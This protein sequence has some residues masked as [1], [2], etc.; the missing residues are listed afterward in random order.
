MK[1]LIV[2]KR[3]WLGTILLMLCGFAFAASYNF[4]TIDF[5]DAAQTRA[6]GINDAGNI[7]G[8]YLRDLRQHGF[9]SRDGEFTTIDAPIDPQPT[10]FVT[11]AYGINSSD[12][13]VGSFRLGLGLPSAYIFD[14]NGLRI[15]NATEFIVAEA[16][17]INDDGTICG[18]FAFTDRPGLH[19]YLLRQ[20][21][22][23]II[24]V[25]DSTS[26]FAFGINNAEDIVG[27]YVDAGGI[28]HG[29][30][31][32]GGRITMIQHPDAA[33]TV[34]RGINSAGSIVGFFDDNAG[35]RHGFVK[36]SG[37]FATIDFPRATFTEA[38]GINS[39]GHVVGD[40]MDATGVIHA[41]IAVP[42]PHKG[43]DDHHD[44]HTQDHEDH[45]DS[46]DKHTHDYHNIMKWPFSRQ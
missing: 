8:T 33:N 43:D 3:V 22:F 4:K 21:L 40:Y 36:I 11:I 7:V 6:F 34:P 16:F 31:S 38:F 29:Y 18:T 1:P 10:D 42:Q 5:P 12:Q 19:S 44:R 15:I 17:G 20:G 37:I 9:L 26:T 41:F 23:S 46:R 2:D 39:K 13:V 32:R 45:H 14:N 27:V 24:D 25:P 30:L 35:R 28:S